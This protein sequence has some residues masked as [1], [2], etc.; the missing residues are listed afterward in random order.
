VTTRIVAS[1]PRAVREI[2]H[3]WIPM[4]DGARLAA[5]L[6]LPDGA[7]RE[8]VSALLEYI[9]YG[10]REG[11]RERDERMHR[12]FAGHGVAA[13]RVDVRGSGDSDGVLADEYDAQELRDGCEVIAWI[14]SQP[15][16]SG[17]V[18]MIGK[19]WGGFNALQIAELR[20]PALRGVIS[21][22]A[23]DDRYADDAHYMGGCLLN[24]NFAWGAALFG[25]VAQPPDP[26]LV[27]EAWS[28]RWHERLGSAEPFAARWLRHPLRDA[29]WRRGSVSED[30]GRIACPVYA[31]GGW[32][33]G[34][35]NAVPR[36]VAG[37]PGRCLGLVG[38]WAH[39]YPHE[40]TPQPPIGFLQEALRWWGAVRDGD[41]RGGPGPAGGPAYRV[42]MPEQPVVRHTGR[43]AGRWVAEAAWPS[44]RIAPRRLTL[45]AGGLG[46]AGS[47]E[48]RLR[49]RSPQ[50]TGLAAGAWCAFGPAGLPGEQDAD[51][52]R[53]LCLDSAPLGERLEILG[54]P[55]VEMEI[56]VDRPVAFVAVRLCERTPDGRSARVTY[57]L[58]NLTHGADH[59]R[60]RPLRPGQR[61]RARVA[62]NDVAHAFAVGSRLRL[63]L[64]TAYWPVVWPSP[65]PVEL[66]LFTGSGFLELPVRPP[67]AEDA[68]LP[69][70]PP[71]EM[72]PG[73]EVVALDPGSSRV[74]VLRDGPGGEVAIEVQLDL[75]AA[76][77]P[78]LSR[79]EP[80]DLEVGYGIRA[81][82]AVHPDDPLAARAE[83]E[84][85]SVLRRGGWRVS[86]RTRTRVHAD[87]ERFHLEA[88]LR[89]C[90]GDAVVLERR[91]RDAVPR[92]GR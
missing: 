67:R 9:P 59:A 57:G 40:G 13:V 34:Y 28:A 11:T 42:W 31:V 18:G 47:R 82:H 30:Y 52:E 33:D 70:F 50:D 80:I 65:E 5:R 20:P 26:A 92:E 10:K 45:G 36:L 48:A 46:D 27:G 88:E 89:A 73:P 90:E 38:P 22:C 43:V 81:R 49:V 41:P 64:S 8:P 19:S 68:D 61:F 15:W 12:Y 6:W 69:P 1:F 91:F 44:P 84:H 77:A 54:A 63:A 74:E 55:V 37:L 83:I 71:A 29:Y 86:T 60:W 72:A 78:A 4:P 17:A 62:L 75:D 16:C 56:A 3:L 87:R 53:S 14:A 2:E 24:E 25:L 66:T 51:D 79:V 76:G 23:S 85:T 58:A 7:E 39:V 35:S 21:V 32:A